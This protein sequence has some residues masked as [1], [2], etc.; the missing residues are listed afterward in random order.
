MRDLFEH[1]NGW[2]FWEKNYAF[3][4][5]P[6]ATKEIAMMKM[7]EHYNSITVENDQPLHRMLLEG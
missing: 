7:A 3:S 6:F 2:Y 1:E 4:Q 5:G